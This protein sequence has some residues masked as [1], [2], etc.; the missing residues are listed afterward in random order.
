[1]YNLIKD[2]LKYKNINCDDVINYTLS[3][4]YFE[5]T[6]RRDIEDIKSWTCNFI[7]LDPNEFYNWQKRLIRKQKL[8]KICM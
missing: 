7:I 1:M 3:E 8:E 5:I 4:N 6:V 2:Y